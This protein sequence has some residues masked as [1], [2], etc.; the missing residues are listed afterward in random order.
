[1]SAKEKGALTGASIRRNIKVPK[2]RSISNQKREHLV[3]ACCFGGS[4]EE[5]IELIGTLTIAESKL[6]AADGSVADDIV[7]WRPL[8]V[9]VVDAFNTNGRHV[10]WLGFGE[11]GD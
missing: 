11:L 10:C 7:G 3:L 9:D 6:G 2:L 8:D 1:M 5:S 4:G